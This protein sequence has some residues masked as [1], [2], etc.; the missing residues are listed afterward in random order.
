MKASWSPAPSRNR[1]DGPEVSFL[2]F[3]RCRPDLSI[4]DRGFVSTAKMMI[5]KHAWL[6][7]FLAL[8]MVSCQIPSVESVEEEADLIL[9][10]AKVFTSDERQPWAQ[11]IAIRDGEFIYV[12]TEAG[13]SR[14]RARTTR[15]VDLEGRLVV[16]GIVDAHAH[17]GYVG[18]EQFGAIEETSREA[19]LAAVQ[20]YAE[21]HPDDEVLRLCC[22]PIEMYV[23]GA[24]GPHKAELDAVVP[25]RPVWFVSDAWHDR[26]LN[27]KALEVLDLDKD[28][29]DPMPGLANYVRDEQGDLTGWVKEGAGWQHFARQ[30]PIADASSHEEAV[31]SA[32]RTL[33]EYGVT[34]LYDAGNFGYDDQVYGFLSR[35][36]REGK[37][38]VRYEGTYQILIPERRKLA[39]SEMKRFREEYGGER[40][41]FNTI[42]LFMDGINENRSGGMQK[43]YTDD[44]DYVANTMLTVAELRDFLIELHEE[45]MDLHVHTIGD[46]AVR[47]VLDA[48]EAAKAVNRDDFYPR[49]TLSHL[50]LIDPADFSRIRDLG[51]VANFTPWWMGV[52]QGDVVEVSLGAER[53]SNLYQPKTLVDL[54]DIVTFSSDEWWGGETLITSLSPYFGMQVGH[55]RQYPREWREE[56]QGEGEVRSPESERLGLDTLVRG[57]TANGAYQ[58]RME[59]EIGS[60]EVGK[61]ADLLV[62]DENLFDVDRYAIWKIKPSIVMMEGEVIRGSLPQ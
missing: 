22:W 21:E 14:Y 11:A 23:R 41:R 44:P 5:R 28:S 12:G 40:L 52:N 36:D 15:S 49:V 4:F 53:Y 18:V 9:T 7:A 37:L 60:V 55:N 24:A 29:V 16:P 1:Q 2:R 30:F 20:A 34:T 38:P 62:F 46:L 33:S 25:N 35:L 39:I 56:G 47:N 3:R 42:K 26:W 8:S 19:M 61:L 45:K 43:P 51:I 54:G 57:Y 32:L 48:V 31:V 6:T 17:P 59:N 27:S 50:E 13:A 58:L 10:G